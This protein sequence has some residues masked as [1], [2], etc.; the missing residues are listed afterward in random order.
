VPWHGGGARWGWLC[1]GG[2]VWRWRCV[3]VVGG[4]DGRVVWWG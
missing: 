2:D 3:R 1:G 4:G